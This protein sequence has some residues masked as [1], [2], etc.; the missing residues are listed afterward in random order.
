M[1]MDAPW[2]APDGSSGP[3][4]FVYELPAPASLSQIELSLG[5]YG[6]DAQTGPAPDQTIHLAVSTQSPTDGFSEIGTYKL[7]GD[8]TK[9]FPISPETKARW[10]K[11][12]I[13]GNSAGTQLQ[14]MQ[15][16]GTFDP[17]PA[18]APVAG[19]WKYFDNFHLDTPAG[20]AGLVAA[21]PLS[22]NQVASTDKILEIHQSGSQLSAA[23]CAQMGAQALQGSETGNTVR[24]SGSSYNLSDAIVNAE[25]TVMVGA[26]SDTNFI[27]LRVNGASCATVFAAAKSSGTGTP[28][29]EL[30]NEQPPSKYPPYDDRTTY[31]E[32]RVDAKPVALFTPQMLGGYGIVAMSDVC[33]ADAIMT[34][35]QTQAL[36]D[37]VYSGGKLIIHD[38]DECTDTDYSFLPYHFTSSNPGPHAAAGSNLVLVES[39]T[40]GSGASDKAHFVDVKGYLAENGQQLGDANTVVTEDQHWCGHLYGTNVLGDNGY[41]QMYAPFGSGLIIYDGLDSDDSDLPEFARIVLLELKQP[42]DATLPCSQ[43]VSTPFAMGGGGDQGFASGKSQQLTV[44]VTLYPTHGFTGTLKMSVNAPPGWQASLSN[45]QV[46]LNGQSGQTNLKVGIPANAAPGRYPVVV[47]ASDNAGH[48]ASTTVTFA[49]A[50]AQATAAPARAEAVPAT[51]KIAKTLAVQ[52][53]VA[54]YGIYFDFASATLKPESALV[55]QEIAS[56]LRANPSWKIIIEGHTDNVGGE[57]YNLDLSRRRAI[58]VKDALVTTYHIDAARLSTV[59]YGY[60]R[61]KASNDT[62]QGR[63]LNRRVELVR[64]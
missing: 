16:T 15:I 27:A 44:P 64:S 25:G 63:A 41:F 35:T 31:P 33:N 11:L 56:A 51:P 12:T 52:K 59:G 62:P 29:L 24:L 50:G 47:S 61:P 39:N 43:L 49:S 5:D 20:V 58:S 36:T 60:S 53:R 37:W 21:L 2:R 8:A 57:A 40:L 26:G 48:T 30:Y 22:E 7:S 38:S 18:S 4:V 42:A 45:S 28:V 34:K 9:D 17:R 1:V 14:D 13:D 55:L 46:P 54:V 23:L 19:A 10:I 32:Y 6:T 3:Y